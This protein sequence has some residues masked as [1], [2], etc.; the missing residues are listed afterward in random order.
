MSLSSSS[1]SPPPNDLL[2][3]LEDPDALTLFDQGP[4]V[5]KK[6]LFKDKATVVKYG[7]AVRRSEALAMEFVRNYAPT[8]PVPEVY[9]VFYS[10]SVTPDESSV[11]TTYI[12]LEWISGEDLSQVWT[13]FSPD[14]KNDIVDQL[15]TIVRAIRALEPPHGHSY[16]GA[17]GNSPC[18]DPIISDQGPFPDIATFNE[19]LVGVVR[20]CFR[21]NMLSVVRR[22]LHRTDGYRIVF[23]HGD[24]HISNIIITRTTTPSGPCSRIVAIIDWECAGWYPEHWEYVKL[25]NNV[26]W[27]SDWAARA[28]D[29][30]DAHYDEDF[31]LY[32]SLA[33]MLL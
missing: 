2:V 27:V 21:G 11:G 23:T 24:L 16:V 1:L 31:W 32:N 13:N 8:V 3:A 25:L 5:T 15:R 19:A 9:G 17:H 33:R 14:D 22:L 20:P 18:T 6:I 7:P 10:P 12:L 28:Q 29:L 30:L 4:K 26:K